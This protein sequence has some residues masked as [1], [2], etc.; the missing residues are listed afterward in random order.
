MADQ[1]VASAGA[2]EAG[3][4]FA[5]WM[6]S[7]QRRVF[8]LCQRMLGEADEADSATQDVFFKAYKALQKQEVP[9]DD[10]AKWLTRIAVNTCLDKLRSRRWQF[11]R[12]RPKQEDEELILNMASSASPDAEAQ[13]FAGEIGVRLQTALGN[14][15]DRQRAVF[16]LRHY[17]DRGLD[18][19]AEI[20]DLDVGTVKAHMARALAKLRLELQDLYEGRRK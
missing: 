1:L 17:E 20:L 6:L 14:L 18:E 9:I 12:K 7:E 13:M 10:S 16:T 19:I 4:D 3:S 5:G 11:W 2:A 8:L 15:S